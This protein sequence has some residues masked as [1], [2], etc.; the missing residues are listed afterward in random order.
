[1]YWILLI[2]FPASVL[3]IVVDDMETC[4]A[5]QNLNHQEWRDAG[6]K[7]QSICMKSFEI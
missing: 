3:S 7:A 5:L 6:V 1:M 2:V 4:Q